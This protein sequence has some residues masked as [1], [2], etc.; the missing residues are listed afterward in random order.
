VVSGK[1]SPGLLIPILG[2]PIERWL[3]LDFLQCSHD[4]ELLIGSEKG[5][6]ASGIAELVR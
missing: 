4:K 6:G 5:V 3:R 1:E 2:V